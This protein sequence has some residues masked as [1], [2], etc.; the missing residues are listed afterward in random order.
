VFVRA[1]GEGLVQRPDDTLDVCGAQ[2]RVQGQ[3]QL[4]PAESFGV[5][6]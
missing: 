1:G 4:V 3:R 6:E 5:R 2:L